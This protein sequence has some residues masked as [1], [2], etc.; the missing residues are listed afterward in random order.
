M[1]LR[2]SDSIRI[3]DNGTG[4][5]VKIQIP[6]PLNTNT[7]YTLPSADG[8]AGTALVTDGLGNLTWGAP[9][10]GG[11]DP[12]RVARAGDSM[13]GSLTMN[14]QNAVRFADADSSNYVG[15]KGAATI[16]S[17]V[18][19]ILPSA[20]GTANY[21]LSTDG[22]GTL[23]WSGAAPLNVLKAGDTM[24]GALLLPAGSAATPSLSFSGDT[25]TGIFSGTADTLKFATA[26]A[27]VARISSTGF[28]GINTTNPTNQLH[29]I[30]VGDIPTAV[31]AIRAD[32]NVTT[33]TG[34]VNAIVVNSTTSGEMADTFGVR[35]AFNVKDATSTE[36]TIAV[37]AGERATA[38][39]TGNLVLMTSSAGVSTT[40]LRITQNGT[41]QL[42]GSTSGTVGFKAA[43]VA[44][45]TNYTLPSADGTS[46]QALS[47]NGSGTLS[48]ATISSGA[49]T[50]LSNLATTA[51]NQDLI[52]NTGAAAF[53]KTQNGS[54]ITKA[55]NLVTGDSS[56]SFSG[57]VTVGSGDG[58]SATGGTTV[59]T[60]NASAGGSS[61]NVSIQSGTGDATGSLNLSSGNASSG[62]S[63]N[64]VLQTGTASGTRGKIKLVDG[65]E[66]TS[67]NVW[68]STASDGSGHWATPAAAG[69]TSV[70]LTVP[71]FLSV[72][73]SP[74][75]SSGTL[76][77]SLSGTAL[78]V[79]NG[80]T[81]LTSGT[82]GGILG[83]TA[84]GTLASSAALAANQLVIGGGAGAT[85][86][87]LGSLG[88]TTTVLHGNA[89]GAPTFGAIS[90]TADVSGTL[91][92][93]NGGTGT[94]NGSITGTT[95]L[96]LAA[97][98]SNQSINLTPTGT[99]IVAVSTGVSTGS[100][101]EGFSGYTNSSTAVTIP[102]TSVS[103]VRYTLTGNAT[104]TFPAFTSP[105]SRVY[106]LTLF[107]KQD[108]TGSRTATFAG[109]GGDTFKWDGGV[110]PS[111]SPTAGKITI[112]QFM[113]AA[114]ETVW[115]ASKVWS[116]D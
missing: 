51:I 33:T 92:V 26:G 40:W 31:A 102:D 93:A 16:P 15:F 87:T 114:D 34:R 35:I 41:M 14:A 11:S 55:L 47:T 108:G 61:S 3:N 107:L 101:Y 66:G 43:A 13:T 115:Y 37:I 48:W 89:G 5:E 9:S 71:T 44:G 45:S 57:A 104:I 23:S 103:V 83:F 24:T 67:G 75:T 86:T 77:V 29:V 49:N 60:G 22:A 63:G 20:D 91:P 72:S 4:K 106:N 109:N 116:E 105:G 74:I 95:A 21:L 46:G 32:R 94:T 53:L 97:G 70:A 36:N 12:T 76:A 52:F 100:V 88:T 112:L 81:G 84:S 19:W 59:K 82:S 18:N 54:G 110:T 1:P 2:T 56:A 30:T 8:T 99:G 62:S 17:N 6:E 85:P 98:G 80:G 25:N 7:T 50:A 38:D 65:S 27:E 64:I 28:V 39:D 90:L 69:V 10:G 113:K 111:I 68:T 79:A 96:T 58:V 78:P 73:G 42:H